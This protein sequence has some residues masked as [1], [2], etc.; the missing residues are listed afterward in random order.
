MEL[1]KSKCRIADRTPKR[2]TEKGSI[3]LS[4]RPVIRDQCPLRCAAPGSREA[5]F[6]RVAHCR[7]PR[8][9][10][11]SAFDSSS[12]AALSRTPCCRCTLEGSRQLG[13]SQYATNTSIAH[14][15]SYFN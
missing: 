10:G 13:P 11:R 2:P 3:A 14:S 12:L 1:R 5:R 9:F 8:R 15:R 7:P 6:D 4:R